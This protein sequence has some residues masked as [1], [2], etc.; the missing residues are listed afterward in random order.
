MPVA[1]FAPTTQTEYLLI[2]KG[3][4]F[5]AIQSWAWIDLDLGQALDRA[6][7]QTLNFRLVQEGLSVDLGR[8]RLGVCC[9]RKIDIPSRLGEFLQSRAF[10][11]LIDPHSAKAGANDHIA[12]INLRLYRIKVESLR[13]S[14]GG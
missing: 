3:A 1:E 5:S 8:D 6:I 7:A 14:A 13:A 4:Q 9:D 12:Y 2:P 11:I 10:N